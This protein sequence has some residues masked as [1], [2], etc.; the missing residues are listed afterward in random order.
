MHGFQGQ[1]DCELHAD[2][3]AVLWLSGGVPLP[4]AARGY[5]YMS[6][7]VPSEPTVLLA[8][9]QGRHVKLTQPQF[10]FSAM[11]AAHL[12]PHCW[13]L[14]PSSPHCP[15]A[16]PSPGGGPSL[17]AA[18]RALLTLPALPQQ[19]QAWRAVGPCAVPAAV[20]A[21]GKGCHAI[22]CQR[23]RGHDLCFICSIRWQSSVRGS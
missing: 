13:H 4:A 11:A 9:C 16:S 1:Q 10:T 2:C 23:R 19:V 17:L 12:Q 18:Q 14:P 6:V 22:A 15:P 3:L 8:L 7:L 20:P 21:R 5:S